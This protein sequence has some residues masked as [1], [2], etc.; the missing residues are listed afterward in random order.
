MGAETE[1]KRQ[2]PVCANC[3]SESVF[4]DAHV[5]W[6]EQEQDWD[7]VTVFDKGHGC[8]DCGAEDMIE[9]KEID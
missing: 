3:G 6:N 4:F 5:M 9:W 1:Q 8:D 7:L 2:Q